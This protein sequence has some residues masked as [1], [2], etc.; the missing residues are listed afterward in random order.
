M[1]I[2]PKS[3]AICRLRLWIELLKHAYYTKES[4]YARL[5]TLPNIDINIKCGNSLISRFALA[6]GD[7]VLPMD[8]ARLKVLV[9]RYREKVLLYK[10]QPT[11]KA[12]LRREIED[13]KEEIQAFSLPNDAE[14]NLLRKLE[15][16]LTQTLLRFRPG[17]GG[18][19]RPDPEASGGLRGRID[20]K[21]RTVDRAAFEWRYEF[22]E[23]LDQNGRFVGFDCV[24]G[25][26][27]Y[28]RRAVGAAFTA[29][30][31]SR[32][33]V[34]HGVADL[35]AY[36]FELGVAVLKEGGQFSI[37]VANK[38][39]RANYG[40]PLRKWL[41]KQGLA[42]VVDFGDLPVFP[43]ATAY[44]C[45]VRLRKGAKRKGF[46]ACN[47]RAS[48]ISTSRNWSGPKGWRLHSPR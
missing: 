46:T 37:I 23:V 20:E 7:D 24:I 1:D 21:K 10:L 4:G 35:Y 16:D 30:A 17:R 27:P 48:R 2:N 25:N 44:P 45:I 11:N 9:G 32:Y 3:V 43:E 5:E 34:Y 47:V 8:R 28:V 38:W 13:M 31:R 40:A 36:F 14:E 12:L 6:G 19:T 39:M 22:P 18:E 26:P 33:E 41:R 42:L 15:N 29:Y